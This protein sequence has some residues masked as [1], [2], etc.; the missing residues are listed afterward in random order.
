MK[1]LK[2]IYIVNQFDAPRTEGGAFMQKT[3]I[4]FDKGGTWKSLTAPSEAK[5][6]CP[7]QTVS[8]Q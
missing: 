7:D 2:G 6:L 8:G 4:T 1:G 5:Q 3:Y